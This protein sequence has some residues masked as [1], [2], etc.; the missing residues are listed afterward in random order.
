MAFKRWKR[1]IFAV[2][3]IFFQRLEIC[4]Y[5]CTRGPLWIQ[6]AC[7]S[8]T[9]RYLQ[10]DVRRPGTEVSAVITNTTIVVRAIIDRKF[11]APVSDLCLRHQLPQHKRQNAAVL[12]VINLNR[13]INPATHRHL[14]HAAVLARD[15][16]GEVLLRLEVRVRGRRCRRSPCRRA[17]GFER[18]CLP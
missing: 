13:R 17:S 1:R 2:S 14:F 18:S 16:Q 10:I 3:Q 8:N 5:C 4:S 9:H 6:I 7:G 11:G 12:V 15:P